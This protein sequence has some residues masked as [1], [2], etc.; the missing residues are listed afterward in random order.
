MGVLYGWCVVLVLI[1]LMVLWFG[2]EIDVLSCC[3]VVGLVSV[4][5]FVWLSARVVVGLIVCVCLCVFVCVIVCFIV[6]LCCC[7]AGVL[8]RRFAV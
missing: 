6:F 7:C 2:G 4:R 8:S 5:L 1:C 3:F